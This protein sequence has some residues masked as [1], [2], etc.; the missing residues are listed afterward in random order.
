MQR[1]TSVIVVSIDMSVP[2]VC[3]S[4]V[5]HQLFSY[6]TLGLVRDPLVKRDLTSKLTISSSCS[7]LMFWSFS[8]K[9]FEFS[10]YEGEDWFYEDKIRLP[11]KRPCVLPIL[12]LRQSVAAGSSVC[13]VLPRRR[14][15][16]ILFP[17]WTPVVISRV[18]L[19]I[20]PAS[21]S[22]FKVL[23]TRW[24]SLVVG[25]RSICARDASSYPLLLFRGLWRSWQCTAEF[26][27]SWKNDALLFCLN[28][29]SACLSYLDRFCFG[30]LAL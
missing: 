11:R 3:R 30:V 28:D 20:F 2:A 18:E 15:R 13:A 1:S 4:V 22:A 9:C 26:P 10:R 21:A 12:L 19:S 14:T 16:V 29:R 23:F 27:F 24:S 5:F 7:I 17:C 25:S 8:A 6:R